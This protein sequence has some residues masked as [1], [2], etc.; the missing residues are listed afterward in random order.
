MLLF[1]GFIML[2]LLLS[3]TAGYLCK[4]LTVPFALIVDCSKLQGD[5]PLHRPYLY[6]HLRVVKEESSDDDELSGHF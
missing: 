4:V 5:L 6:D 2:V 1:G 3:A